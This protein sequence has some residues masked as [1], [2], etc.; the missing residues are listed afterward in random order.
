MSQQF[1]EAAAEL[2]KMPMTVEQRL[3]LIGR[4][5]DAI[6]DSSE[7]LPI[8]SWH[9][10]VLRERLAAADANPDAAMPWEELEKKLQDES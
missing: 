10:Q 6:P 7:A 4:L 8:P 2:L 1:P 5:W 3:D 9:Q